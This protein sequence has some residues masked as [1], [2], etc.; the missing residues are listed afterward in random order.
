M[1]IGWESFGS[2]FVRPA[3]VLVA[4]TGLLLTGCG[5]GGQRGQ[6]ESAPPT[7]PLDGL[8]RLDAHSDRQTL[9]GQPKPED[10]WNRYYAVRTACAGGACAGSVV[11]VRD[12]DHAQVF[13]GKDGKAAEPFY[14]DFIGETWISVSRTEY[15]CDDGSVGTATT[16]WS[17]T[18]QP[19]QTLTGVR[20]LI[21]SA[22]PACG[23][24]WEVPVALTRVGDAD[25][26]VVLP[27]PAEADPYRRSA[28]LGLRGRYARTVV[29]RGGEGEPERSEVAFESF[30]VRNTDDCIALERTGDTPDNTSVTPLTFGAGRWST[31]W[32][33]KATCDAERG[34]AATGSVQTATEQILLPE[35]PPDP[36]AKL[37][38]SSGWRVWGACTGTSESDVTLE[39]VGD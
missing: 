23:A 1:K 17:L 25:P 6:Q 8:F 15:D 34:A 26:A 9:F 3:L 22:S 18:P 12:D 11:R 29:K 20:H 38:G 5:S 30:C 14:L 32:N 33:G 35:N 7:A 31:S 19:D 28:P 10:P 39:R 36:I 13:V 21:R 2:R 16:V 37:V 27:D 24:A 4:L